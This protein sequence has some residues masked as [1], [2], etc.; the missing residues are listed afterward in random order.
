MY[1]K[2]HSYH[3]FNRKFH[4]YPVFDLNTFWINDNTS[5]SYKHLTKTMAKTGPIQLTP[6]FKNNMVVS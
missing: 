5:H 6:D 1:L 4:L 3:C 2:K